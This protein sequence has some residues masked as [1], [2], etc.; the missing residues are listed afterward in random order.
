MQ[1]KIQTTPGFANTLR[2]AMPKI[3]A[4][5]GITG[6]YKGLVPLWLRQ[7]P[8]TM[9][10]FACF[11]RTLELLYKYVV[12]KPRQEC[13]KGEQLVVTFAAGYIA[14]VFC[15]IVSHPAD[16]V[17]VYMMYTHFYFYL[18]YLFSMLLMQYIFLG[19]I[20]IESRKGS[21]SH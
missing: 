1:V 7:V 11:E 21:I 15:A 19:C 6:F 17:S 2:E 13:S 16:S 14:G 5:E 9:M 8:Y 20:K 10:K 4:E 3:Y 12:P 18:F